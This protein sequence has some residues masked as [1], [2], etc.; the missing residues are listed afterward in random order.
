MASVTVLAAVLRPPV[1]A[2]VSPDEVRILPRINAPRQPEHQR[3]FKSSVDL[4]LVNVTVTDSHDRLVHDLRASDFLLA[5]DR[6]PQ[7]I[8]Y[9]SSEDLPISVAVVVDASGSMANKFEQARSA[10]IEFFRSS[11]PQDEFAVVTL[12]DKPRLLTHFTD[13]LEEI[14]SVLQPIQPG[15]ETALWD[16]VYLGLQE[17]RTARYGKKALLVISDGGDNSSRYTQAEIKSVLQEADVQLY[18]IDIFE[19]FPKTNEERSGLLALDEVTSA[20]GGRAFLTHDSND[21]HRAVR[22]ISE[23]LRTQYVLGYLPDK[24]M[25]DG[26]WHKIKVEMNATKPRKLRIYAKKGY[27]SPVDR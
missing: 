19:R 1:L 21:L 12:S 24:S 16:A 7:H 2:Q 25:R 10:A 6:N 18:A 27:Y 23:E 4:V 15:G 26:K 3:A 20:T 11:N 13:S 14:K 5:D 8:R 22:Q 17:M 9:F